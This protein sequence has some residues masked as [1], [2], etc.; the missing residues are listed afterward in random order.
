MPRARPAT[1]AYCGQPFTS[2]HYPRTGWA[3]CCSRTCA[4]RLRHHVPLGTTPDKRGRKARTHDRGYGAPHQKL[5]AQWRPIVD[6]GDASCMELV[7][8]MP[9]RRIAPGTD[10]DLAHNRASGGYRG[11]AHQ[12]CNRAEGGRHSPYGHRYQGRAKQTSTK[13]TIPTW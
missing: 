9:S 7:C 11:P 12:R 13:R 5:K 1:C 4:S 6:R 3:R 2:K 10:W 8:V